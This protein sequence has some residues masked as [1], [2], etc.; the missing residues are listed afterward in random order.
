MENNKYFRECNN[1][2]EILEQNRL[3]K[4]AILCIICK[5]RKANRLFLPCAHMNICNF[6]VDAVKHHC[7]KC[8]RLIQGVVAVYL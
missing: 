8:H 6:C 3:L 2:K 7:P 4:T 5:D 1:Y